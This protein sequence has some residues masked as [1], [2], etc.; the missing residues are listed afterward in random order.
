GTPGTLSPLRITCHLVTPSP[1][2]SLT[3]A[4]TVIC[5]GEGDRGR[6]WRWAVVQASRGSILDSMAD[7]IA[8][9]DGQWRFVQL[10]A[11]AARLAG[12]PR[13]EL[14]GRSLWELLPVRVAGPI[15]AQLHQAMDRREA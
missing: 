6:G 2:H 12:R 5:T 10:N 9:F 8:A 11:A 3:F 7:A 14:L 1:Y 15:V 13:E 4:R